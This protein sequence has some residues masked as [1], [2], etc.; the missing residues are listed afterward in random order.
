MKKKSRREEEL[1]IY[2]R[3]VVVLGIVWEMFEHWLA[4]VSVWNTIEVCLFNC[5]LEY[6]LAYIL[7]WNTIEVLCID[8]IIDNCLD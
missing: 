6:C 4:Q 7:F 8:C 3:D 2:L 5:M 1:S